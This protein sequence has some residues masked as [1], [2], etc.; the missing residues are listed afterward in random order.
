MAANRESCSPH[1]CCEAEIRPSACSFL[2]ALFRC[3][4]PVPPVLSFPASRA[5]RSPF[6]HPLVGGSAPIPCFSQFF[7]LQRRI[8]L[9]K[10]AAPAI[11]L[12]EA[13]VIERTISCS[14]SPNFFPNIL[15]PPGYSA[16]GLFPMRMVMGVLAEK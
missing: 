8:F 5:H 14:K 6:V 4:S 10:D 1:Y 11:Q 12:S 13:Y 15:K 16:S 9:R 3:Q 7:V 2:L